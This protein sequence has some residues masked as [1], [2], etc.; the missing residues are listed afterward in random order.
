MYRTLSD[1]KCDMGKCRLKMG[2]SKAFNSK[3]SLRKE[4]IKFFGYDYLQKTFD[5]ENGKK[6]LEKCDEETKKKYEDVISGKRKTLITSPPHFVYNSKLKDFS[7]M[8]DEVE[9][10]AEDKENT[11]APCVTYSSLR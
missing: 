8:E 4:G 10:K 1:E 3:A 11:N 5:S 9:K 6:I 7:V 2:A